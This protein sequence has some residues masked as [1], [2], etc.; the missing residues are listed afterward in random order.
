[1]GERKS[2][3]KQADAITKLVGM[4]GNDSLSMPVMKKDLEEAGVSS[5]TINTLTKKGIFRVE[6]LKVDRFQQ[7]GSDFSKSLQL[8]AAQEKAYHEI[9]SAFAANKTTLLHG[10]TGSG[11]TE[12][13]IRLIQ[14]VIDQ[15]KQVLFLLPEIALTTQLIQRLKAY[16]GDLVGVYHSK[17]NQNE[18]VDI[19]YHVL[20][21]HPKRF[22]IILGA[23]SSLFL[24]FTNLGLVI[25]DEEHETSFKQYNPSPRYHARD[26]AIIL[27]NFFKCNCLLGSAT[28]SLETYHNAENGKFALVKLTERYGNAHLPEIFCAD[29]QK[30]RR[31]NTMQGDFSSLLISNIA[32]ALKAGSQVILFQNRRGYT[33][34]W[35]CEVCNW[36]PRCVNCDVALTYHK[37]SN[38][39]KCHYCGYVTAPIG[40]CKHC[41]SNRLHM[42]GFGTEKIEDDL[43]LVFPTAKIKRMDLDSTRSKNAY[44]QLIDDFE[45]KKID[46]LVGTQMLS[47]G[48]DFENVSLV[49][50]LDADQMLNMPNFRAFERSFQLMSQV[51]GRAGRKDKRGKVIIQTGQPEHWIIREVMENNYEEFYHYELEERQK[52]QYPPYFKLITLILRHKEE[53]KVSE[54]GSYLA[55]QLREVL[56]N[57]IMGPEFPIVKR[58]NNYYLKQI[59]V[60][61][62]RELPT[63]KI[64][65]KIQEIIDGF[66]AQVPF[67]SIQIN[68]DVDPN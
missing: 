20:N 30:E 39:L 13:Y 8:S 59:T 52:F 35:V 29:L 9:K 1:L 64:K 38:Q 53:R 5:S 49:G 33:P 7:D 25:V 12:I 61:I 54:G 45:K 62:E 60:K 2:N 50:I 23:R 36:T 67:K 43:S 6:K 22:R 58:I 19:W 17:F 40:S 16:F 51:A 11:K 57:R 18:R 28:P 41:G 37:A 10:I 14:E 26:M 24:P 44:F 63:K 15:G 42:H 46:I 27:S 55:E 48:L 56:G 66:Y 68:I 21:N 65:E 3:E 32:E 4:L 31:E 34:A 47:K